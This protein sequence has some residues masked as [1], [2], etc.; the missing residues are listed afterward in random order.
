MASPDDEDEIDGAVPYTM[1]LD[2][3]SRKLLAAP[4]TYNQGGQSSYDPSPY[5]YS[6]AF[7]DQTSQIVNNNGY[8]MQSLGEYGLGLA[9]VSTALAL[10]GGRVQSAMPIIVLV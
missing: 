6:Q 1:E 5:L 10:A 8:T 7:R 3:N 4:T 2:P 9:P